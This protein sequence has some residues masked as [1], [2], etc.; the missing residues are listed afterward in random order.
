MVLKNGLPRVRT[1]T[2]MTPRGCFAGPELL[3]PLLPGP[4]PT[5][6]PA[7]TTV[8]HKGRMRCSGEGWS[9]RVNRIL[10]TRAPF[11]E[12]PMLPLV[13][14]ALL[15]ADRP[16]V[17]FADFEGDTYGD[18]TTTGTAF[19][20]GPAKGTL[21]GQTPVTGYRGKG[22]VNS[23][24]GGDGPTGTLTSPEFTINR[25]YITFLIGGGGFAGRTCVNLL[26]GGKV[27]RTATG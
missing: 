26:V 21:P 2:P 10:R 15:A 24:H 14:A 1:E 17:L 16:D 11:E 9:G 5:R 4:H 25:R 8:T 23:F 18:W 19:G 6:M 13:F 27:A 20:T 3:G 12:S 7:T 22:L